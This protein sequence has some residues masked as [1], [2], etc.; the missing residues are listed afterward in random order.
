MAVQTDPED[1]E[2]LAALALRL[3]IMTGD[4]EE[5]LGL[6][7][8]ALTANQHSAVVLRNCA[9][10]NLHAGQA[11]AAIALFERSL[12]LGPTDPPVYAAWGG[13]RAG[14]SCTRP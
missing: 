6:V 12:R 3:S 14:T 2:A 7:A 8:R 10:A 13:D 5:V 9:L 1:A 4:V 11:E